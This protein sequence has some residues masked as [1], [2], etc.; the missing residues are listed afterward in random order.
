MEDVICPLPLL[1]MGDT[2][3]VDMY[4]TTTIYAAPN[5]NCVLACPSIV[6][7][8]EEWDQLKNIL[9]VGS[10]CALICSLTSFISHLTQFYKYYIRVMF[11]GGFLTS[12]AIVFFF[13]VMN[14]YVFISYDIAS[15]ILLP[16]YL[17]ENLCSHHVAIIDH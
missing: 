1:T 14:R 16:Y 3:S 11:I 2:T 4:D 15:V 7:D 17:W 12:S 6:Y 5:T 13:A 10:L 9:F 8:E